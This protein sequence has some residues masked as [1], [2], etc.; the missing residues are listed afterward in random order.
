MNVL[1]MGMSVDIEKTV[2]ITH[3]GGLKMPPGKV[4]HML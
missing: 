3:A 4:T 1:N 2:G